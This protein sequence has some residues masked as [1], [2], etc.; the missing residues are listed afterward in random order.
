MKQVMMIIMMIR[1]MATTSITYQHR[2][3]SDTVLQSPLHLFKPQSQGETT[4]I[5]E[6]MCPVT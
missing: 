5:R 3:P 1:V 6:F 4:A 2:T